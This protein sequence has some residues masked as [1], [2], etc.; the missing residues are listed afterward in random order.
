[1]LN[2]VKSDFVDY[3]LIAT[4]TTISLIDIQTI[5]SIVLLSFNI[6]WLMFK[7]IVKLKEKLNDGKLTKEELNELENDVEEINNT[8][9][10]G[11]DK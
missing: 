2:N 9:K 6:L 8:F 5:M 7:F 10:R 11:G 4:G 1:M 3:T